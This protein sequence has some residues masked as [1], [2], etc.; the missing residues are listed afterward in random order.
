MLDASAALAYTP[1][2]WWLFP[3]LEM[4][5]QGDLDKYNCLLLVPQVIIRCG[6]HLDFNT[7]IGV[8]LTND[9]PSTEAR[10]QMTLRF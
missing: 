7:G 5:F 10:L 3:V 2:N 6:C 8:N 9:G 1:A 4:V